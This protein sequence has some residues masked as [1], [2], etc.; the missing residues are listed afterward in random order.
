MAKITKTISIKL[1]DGEKVFPIKDLSFYNLVCDLEGQGIDVMTLTEG[2][3]DRQKLFTTVRAL[4]AVMLGIK[5]ELAGNYI[6]EHI[7]NGGALDDIFGAFTEAMTDAGF[8]NRPQDHQKPQRKTT[9]GRSTK[10]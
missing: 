9:G 7:R 6:E 10:K 2:S 5:P 3:L 8:G 4:L 1:D